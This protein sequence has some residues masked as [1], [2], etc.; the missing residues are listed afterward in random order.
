LLV[1]SIAFALLI[2]EVITR[3]WVPVRNVG[4]SFTTYDSV[5]GKRLKR[6][7]RTIRRAPEFTMRLSTNSRGF[8]GP[9]LDTTGARPVLFLG[10]SYTMGYGVNDGEEYPALV[11]EVLHRRSPPIPVVN[12]GVGDEGNA[13]WIK[14]LR[15]EG[16]ALN[17]RLVVMQISGNDFDDN[18]RDGLFSL[19]AA[20]VLIEN[21][22]PPPGWPRRVQQFIEA[23]PGLAH[24]HLIG[25]SRQA[26]PQLRAAPT[27][28]PEATEKARENADSLTLR[29]IDGALKLCRQNGWPVAGLSVGVE[30]PR[31]AALRQLFAQRGADVLVIP[32]N[33]TRPDLYYAIDR[34]W[35]RQG[36]RWVAQQVMGAI[37][38]AQALRP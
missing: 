22:I 32:D 11:R 16:V 24:S 18:V 28:S 35:N 19:S 13:R 9:E 23:V 33:S 5:Y 38:G 34:H 37:Q 26:L 8:R 14:F 31:L 12:A 3:I 4:P 29:I 30:E 21:P 7:F 6:D 36:H 2:A 15:T 25:L 27:A 1:G 10:D 17:P 20:G